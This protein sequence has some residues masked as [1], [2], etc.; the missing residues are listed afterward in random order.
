MCR[1]L[2]LVVPWF[3]ALSCVLATLPVAVRGAAQDTSPPPER[4]AATIPAP[5]AM[6][7]FLRRAQIVSRRNAGSGVTDSVR[8]TLSDGTLTHDAQI[9]TVDVSKT[10]FQA[11]KASEVNF[12]DSYRYNIAGYRLAR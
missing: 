10:V 2:R 8:A 4:V 5:E 1:T 9:Q 12:R 7:V 3:L 6:E 11:G